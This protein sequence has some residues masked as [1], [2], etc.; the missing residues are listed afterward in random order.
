MARLAVRELPLAHL[1]CAK[2]IR[3]ESPERWLDDPEEPRGLQPVR[4]VFGRPRPPRPGLLLLYLRGL[5]RIHFPAR[6][7]LS[8]DRE[9]EKRHSTSSAV[10]RNENPAR[11]FAVADLADHQ[12]GRRA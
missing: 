8:S 4:R 7:R 5:P 2:P 11:H 12:G 9:V 3:G 6:E 10:S 1:Q